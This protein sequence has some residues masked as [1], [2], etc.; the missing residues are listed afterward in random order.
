MSLLIKALQKAEQSKENGGKA[1]KPIAAANLTLEPTPHHPPVGHDTSLAEEGGFTEPTLATAPATP[2]VAAIPERSTERAAAANVFHAK[3]DVVTDPG[4]RKA[5]WLGLVGLALLLLLGGGFYV[6]L[7]T[8]QQPEI[9]AV[10]PPQPIKPVESAATPA[11]PVQ[12]T[13]AASAVTTAETPAPV[14][15]KPAEPLPEPIAPNKPAVAATVSTAPI[16]KMGKKPA[17]EKEAVKITRNRSSEPVA[18]ATAVAAYQAFMAGDD[19]AAGRLYRQLLQSEPRNVDALLGLAAV[20]A[21]Q[22]NT[23]EAVAQYARAL[24]LE[25]KN[26]VAQSGLIALM[27]QADPV[28]AESRMKSLLAQQPDAAYLHAALGSVYAEQNQWPNAQQSYFQAFR[29]DPTNAEHAFNLAISLDQLAKPELALEYYQRTRDLL[30]KQGGSIDRTTL[31]ARINQLH[32]ALG[33]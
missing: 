10:P 32:S 31:E 23:D 29:L 21:R 19:V 1:E 12:E 14:A 20:A 2:T 26:S 28:A 6:Y 22:A 33:K 13:P 27:S 15:E 11:A 30:P 18:N 5:F 3:I 24:E 4:G 25:P 9:I 16:E 17:P 7:E 8:S